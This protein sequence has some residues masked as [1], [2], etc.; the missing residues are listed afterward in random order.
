MKIEKFHGLLLALI[1]VTY[2]AL[3]TLYALYT[4]KWQVPDE[5]AHYNYVKY[6]AE[7]GTFP[8]LQM[9][10]YPHDYL[11]ELKSKK[12]PDD[13]PIDPI[14]YESHQPPLYYLLTAAIYK[15]TI[16][17]PF[18]Q[19]FLTLRLVSVAIGGT[20][21]YI[22]Y[23]IAQEVFPADPLLPLAT[24]AFVATVPMH[25]AMTAAINND[26]LAEL[27]LSAVLLLLLK[28]LRSDFTPRQY[29]GLG[30]LIGL[31]LITKTTT[32]ISIPL[33]ILALVVH[34]VW[35][36]PTDREPRGGGRPSTSA[37]ARRL[38]LVF[39]LALA[40]ALPWFMRNS[41]TYGGWDILGLERHSAVVIGQPRTLELFPNYWEA[42]RAFFPI[43]FRSFWAQF[44]WMG[45]LVDS[46]LYLVLQLI[47]AFVA[48]GIIIF[49]VKAL[50]GRQPL[51]P[52]QRWGL[53]LLALS[54]LFTF[55]TTLWYSLELFQAQGRYLFPS[56]VSIALFFVVGLQEMLKIPGAV[57]RRIGNPPDW[58]N[59][60]LLEARRC[61][62]VG[63]LLFFSGMVALDLISLFKFIVP[64]LS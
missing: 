44:G 2:L 64:Y 47:C 34:Q 25:V 45:V 16:F 30:L 8:V 62:E 55:S 6:L 1:I 38:L 19:Q 5:P 53:A 36:P 10:D 42:A 32:Y 60:S 24:A 31:G 27:M 9:G 43:L 50:S 12:F 58:I 51:T 4:P 23:G 52:Y 46:R 48:A 18:D 35:L 63:L 54:F 28:L 26:A 20:L 41:L 15:A 40:I 14:R 49:L 21:L 22:T 3:G 7:T 39:G 29:A 37:L 13:M 57:L 61:Q 59:L 56:I 11:E 17:L 33:A